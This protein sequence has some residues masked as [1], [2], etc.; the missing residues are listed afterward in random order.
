MVFTWYPEL[1]L[2][3]LV[4][5]NEVIG[6]LLVKGWSDSLGL[7]EDPLVFWLV[8]PPKYFCNFT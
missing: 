5:P 8:H 3:W 4:Y 6:K 7:R 1:V 2:P